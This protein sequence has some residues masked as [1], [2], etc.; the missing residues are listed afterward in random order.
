MESKI[1]YIRQLVK[2]LVAG[3]IPVTRLN[4]ICREAEQFLRENENLLLKKEETWNPLSMRLFQQGCAVL[5]SVASRRLFTSQELS[6]LR[7][8]TKV[9]LED[10]KEFDNG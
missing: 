1:K 3:F 6:A 4:G 2:E 9:F 7:D 5:E 10:T 8:N